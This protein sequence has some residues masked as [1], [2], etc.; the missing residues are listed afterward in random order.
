MT[1]WIPREPIV[2]EILNEDVQG[3]IVCISLAEFSVEYSY[4]FYDLIEVRANNGENCSSLEFYLSVSGALYLMYRL[5]FGAGVGIPLGNMRFAGDD[6]PAPVWAEVAQLPAD[7]PQNYEITFYAA[8]ETFNDAV[9]SLA[10]S[11]SFTP[12]Q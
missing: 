6:R 8:Q 3:E 11:Q 1:Q 12:A 10:K 7:L 9:T 5:N 2:L 4:A